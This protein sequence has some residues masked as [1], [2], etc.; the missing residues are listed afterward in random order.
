MTPFAVKCLAWMAFTVGNRVQVGNQLKRLADILTKAA[1]KSSAE[2]AKQDT[3]GIDSASH[4]TE[5]PL[6]R[7]A[8]SSNEKEEDKSKGMK[9]M[10]Q[11][12]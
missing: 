8:I 7:K 9:L 2:G 11:K 4:A 12:S 5:K 1:Q 3:Q 10:K 6:K